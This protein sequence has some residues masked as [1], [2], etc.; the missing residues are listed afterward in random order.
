MVVV[1]AAAAA[2]VPILEQYKT[3]THSSE[4]TTKSQHQVQ[5]RTTF[6]MILLG[7]FIVIHLFPSKNQPTSSA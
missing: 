6:N 1:A 3:N 4:P 2:A 5:H 7:H